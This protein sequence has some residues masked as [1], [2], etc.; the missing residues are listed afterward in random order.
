[1]NEPDNTAAPVKLSWRAQHYQGS[2]THV[3]PPVRFPAFAWFAGRPCLWSFLLVNS[4]VAALLV[5]N[6]DVRARAVT[7]MH[8]LPF[9][10]LGPTALAWL[11]CRHVDTG[12]D[13]VCY[14]IDLA[15]KQIMLHLWRSSGRVDIVRVPFAAITSIKPHK[16]SESDVGGMWLGY[17]DEQGHSRLIAMQNALCET[18]IQAHLEALRPALGEKIKDWYVSHPD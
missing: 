5:F 9:I 18:I 8:F 14:E 17:L 3:P 10:L 12:D 13:V 11:M 2:S 6:A 4:L 1:M 15:G 16:S 7:D